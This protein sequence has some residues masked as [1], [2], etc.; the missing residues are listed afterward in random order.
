MSF[1]E[2]MRESLDEA[3]R[4]LRGGSAEERRQ[5][6]KLIGAGIVTL[7]AVVMILWYVIGGG[8]GAGTL[9]AKPTSVTAWVDDLRAE[10][11]KLQQ[12]G[13]RRFTRVGPD[14]V[15]D[16]DGKEAIVITGRVATPAAEQALRDLVARRSP[17]L[18]VEWKLKVGP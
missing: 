3:K 18:S 11:G 13:E 14:V 8:G 17:P 6:L 7:L 5:L 2:R 15:L 10:M 16:K 12:G 9:S 1:T 4:G